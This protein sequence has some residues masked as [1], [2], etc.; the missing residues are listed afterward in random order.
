M[1]SE[2]DLLAVD[3]A[4]AVVNA[5]VAEVVAAKK[6]VVLDTVQVIDVAAP[7]VATTAVTIVVEVVAVAA[8]V[9][10]DQTQQYAQP[11]LLTASRCGGQGAG[12]EPVDHF[13]KSEQ[14]SAA[15][16]NIDSIVVTSPTCHSERSELNDIVPTAETEPIIQLMS[17]PT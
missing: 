8:G 1:P 5:V 9:V 10:V 2:T 7:V 16:Q 3:P 15:F 11:K 17:C 14:N 6:A 13:D 12:Y 4:A